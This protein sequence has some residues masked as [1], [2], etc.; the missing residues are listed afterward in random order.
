MRRLFDT[1]AHL[2]VRDFSSDLG[3][4]LDRA[5]SVGVKRVIA[6]AETLHDCG[7]N[8]ELAT[9]FPDMIAPAGGLFP[10]R[11]DLQEAD[12]VL[13]LIRAHRREWIAV[14]EVGL[15]YWKVKEESE[16]EVQREILRRFVGLG[17]ELDLPLNVHSRSA[18]H[19]AIEFLLLQGAKRVQMHAFDG[20]AA[21][22]L[23]GVEAGFFFSVPPSVVRSQQKQKLVRRLPLSCL[24]LET[25]SPVLGAQ[26]GERNEPANT[27]VALQA[28]AELKGLT[29]EA[30]AD[31][32]YENTLRLYG[33]RMSAPARA[34]A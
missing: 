28:V 9:A 24:L 31:A 29:E 12:S 8:L 22:A 23:A 10:T 17:L 3:S 2:C 19:H 14:G 6:V 32:V 15:D 26:P 18:G 5:R 27:M 30:V 1:H 34:M 20:R 16:R 33:P 25:D 11:L 21:R 4:V 13:E 7:R